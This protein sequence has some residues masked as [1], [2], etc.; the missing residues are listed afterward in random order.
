MC[1]YNGAEFLPAQLE[2]IFRQTRPADEIVVCDDGSTDETRSLIP[3]SV[4]FH[5]N[6]KNLG[7][8]KNFE[9][10]IGLCTG[11]VVVLSDQDDV[12][13]Q[14]KLQLIE[15]AFSRNPN[16]GLVFSDAD[17]V[18]EQLNPLGRRMWDEVGFGRQRACARRVDNR[19]DRQRRH[20]GVSLEIREAVAADP[21]D[22]AHDS[23]R[24]DRVDSRR[25]V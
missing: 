21:N 6:E 16:V 15:E 22:Y 8:V 25:R 23:R 14:D 4:V 19:L 5:E 17:V 9:K 24:L 1:T 2:S 7:T 11:D 20:D 13:R 10:A 18:D 3:E 12:W